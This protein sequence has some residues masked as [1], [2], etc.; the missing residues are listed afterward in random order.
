LMGRLFRRSGPA[1]PRSPKTPIIY[2]SSNR[3]T[4]KIEAARIDFEKRKARRIA[5]L[6]ADPDPR[7]L[8]YLEEARHGILSTDIRS[9]TI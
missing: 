9:P 1:F 6:E 3:N 5:E 2:A 7:K 8:K 4:A